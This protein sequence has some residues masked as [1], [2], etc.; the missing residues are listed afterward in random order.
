MTW[1]SFPIFAGACFFFALLALIC[2]FCIK[3]TSYLSKKYPLRVVAA[4]ASMTMSALVLLSFI[5]LLWYSLDRPPF[6]TMGETR[7]WYSLFLLLMGWITWART[8]FSGVLGLSILMS[9]VFLIINIARP[10]LHDKELMPVLNSLWFVP[11]VAV[12]MFAYALIG[13]AFLIVVNEGF[14]RRWQP[15]R[16]SLERC[17]KLVW[18]GLSLLTFGMMMGAL[19]AKQSWGNYWSW[20]PKETWAAITWLAG[21][22]Y[23]HLRQ[24]KALSQRM[25]YILII[26][27]FLLFQFCWYGI[28]YLP[29]AQGSMH[30]YS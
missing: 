18:Q 4:H 16:L 28:N 6:K 19:W 15:H 22:L 27:I 23:I 29:A 5:I 10:E 8:R 17:D 26:V 20:D 14:A 25:A 7:L 11:H 3:S 13:C 30:V 9:T 24:R 21:L 2:S 1:D 12:Y